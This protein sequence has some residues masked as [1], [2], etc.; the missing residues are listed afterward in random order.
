MNKLKF[1]KFCSLFAAILLFSCSE[2]QKE[3]ENWSVQSP[4]GKISMILHQDSLQG[5]LFYQVLLKNTEEKVD[6][7]LTNSP[8]GIDRL[9]DTFSKNLKFVSVSEVKT[10]N[11]KYPTFTGKR[12]EVHNYANERTFTYQS[13]KG[14]KVAIEV[15][16]F[17][18][19][20]G[21]R[22]VFPE[23]SEEIYTVTGE[24][25][26]F[27][28]TRKG[29][30]W[31]QPYDEVTKWTPAY[32]KYYA[33]NVAIGETSPNP[34]GWCFPAL[35]QTGNNWVLLTEAGLYD[36]FYGA[37]IQSNFPSLQYTIGLPEKTEANG[38]GSIHPEHSLPWHTPWRVVVLGSDLATIVETDVVKNLAKPNQIEDTSWIKPGKASWSW[39]SD[40]ES[41][42]SFTSMKPFVDLAVEM[43]WEYTLID[44]NWNT[45]QDGNIED[46]IAYGNSKGV[47]TILWYN[48]GGPHNDVEEGPRNLMHDPIKRKEEFKK[49][50]S[51]GVK[52]VKIDFF[53]SDKPFLLQQ[54][55][56]ILKDA[57]DH[58]IMVNFHG[59]TIPRGWERTFPNLITM[60]SV[61]GAESYSFAAEYPELAPSNNTILPAT[62]NVIGSMDYTPVAFSD[63]TY[64]HLTTNVHELALAV[65]FESG[66]Q[67]MADKVEAYRTLPEIPKQFLKDVPSTWDATKYLQ[68]IPGNEMILARK[69]GEDW[70][71]AGINGEEISKNITIDFSFLPKGDFDGVFI[72]D[73]EDPRSFDSENIH[74]TSSDKLA[75]KMNNFGGFVLHV[76]KNK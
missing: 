59:S 76:K 31:M 35:F 17:N 48:S 54:Y 20:V 2:I 38:L 19:A 5:A 66:W 25:T 14:N 70:F 32:E 72:K 33:S 30:A 6:T 63:N 15:R 44:A 8:L 4:D 26:G 67:H 42:K 69:K 28:F 40:H 23:K 1:I 53:Q 7:I 27:N 18:D 58:Q 62:R 29:R 49:I 21:F 9:D 52:G 61:R 43:G 65:I 75:V 57:A 12:S 22:Y 46:L 60:E 50:S 41:S 73:A 51:W 71:I 37:R 74:I 34:T 24:S 11:E 13:E 47:G 16:V 68:G 56:G 64:A 39:W 3:K 55:L 10:I 36:D 45:M